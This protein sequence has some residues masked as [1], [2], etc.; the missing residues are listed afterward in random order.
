MYAENQRNFQELKNKLTPDNPQQLKS[1]YD[2]NKKYLSIKI[3]IKKQWFRTTKQQIQV[4]I[5]R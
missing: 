2:L 4:S 5:I 1:W 3:H